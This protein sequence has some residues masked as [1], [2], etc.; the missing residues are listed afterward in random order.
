M[1]QT[2]IGILFFFF[3]TG[4]L[5][6]NTGNQFGIGLSLFYPTG[7]SMKYNISPDLGVEGTLGYVG[8]R[9]HLHA[10]ILYNFYKVPGSNPVNLYVGGGFLMQER[11]KKE[12]VW[13]WIKTESN[14][15][16]PGL[17]VPFGVSIFP[18]G[19][20]FEIFAEINLNLF[21]NGEYGGS[22]LGLAL[23]GRVYF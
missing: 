19:K 4:S 12:K 5:L 23:G 1:K 15:W 17:R 20:Q 7:I 9:S 13:K 11:T 2:I 10:Q 22:D 21:M 8:S 18:G 3:L 14:T 6:A 16:V